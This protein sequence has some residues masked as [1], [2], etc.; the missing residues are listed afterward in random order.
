MPS[1]ALFITLAI[2]LG[3]IDFSLQQCSSYPY[4]LNTTNN[5]KVSKPQRMKLAMLGT[6]TATDLLAVRAFTH[7]LNNNPD[8]LPDVGIDLYVSPT[9]TGSDALLGSLYYSNTNKVHGIIG[10]YTSTESRTIQLAAK[11][12]NVP[13]TTSNSL[14]YTLTNKDEYPYFMRTLPNDAIQIEG[15]VALFQKFG[16]KKAIVVYGNDDYGSGNARLTI[17][18]AVH[19]INFYPVSIPA[20]ATNASQIA[21]AVA[22]ITQAITAQD[23]R[24]VVYYT[25]YTAGLLVRVALNQSGFW[26]PDFVTIFT[27]PMSNVF[28]GGTVAD[29]PLNDGAIG[30]S[31]AK[32]S[33]P[34]Y[35]GLLNTWKTSTTNPWPIPAV[36]TGF[37]WW[38]TVD[39]LL[40]YVYTFNK[41]LNSGVPF[42]S[43]LG[44]LYYKG[45]V[46]NNFTG[47]TGDIVFDNNGDR[48][49]IYDIWSFTRYNSTRAAF[50]S[51]LTDNL[52]MV[53][54]FVFTGGKTAIP[55]D[56]PYKCPA[57]TV[58][59]SRMLAAFVCLAM[60]AQPAM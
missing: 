41:L 27:A 53:S 28:L 19:N 50:Y 14:S 29:Y 37:S 48:L 47:A 20:T 45:L 13:Q 16:W 26:G 8:I 42:A 4:T 56:S 33:G 17:A 12:Y 31:I 36:I 9:P 34:V 21:D 7:E 32:P 57:Y 44:N 15:I 52:T 23:Y 18:G 10:G 58:H 40:N 22:T 60:Q 11:I 39:A 46:A 38:Y 3:L 35:D 2:C 30:F 5:I 1:S 6:W 24:I 51:G 54:P 59:A 55:R 43:I 49:G 25:Q